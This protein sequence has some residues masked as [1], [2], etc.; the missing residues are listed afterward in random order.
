M[1]ISKLYDG[2]LK[3]CPRCKGHKY[4]RGQKVSYAE[5]SQL[6]NYKKIEAGVCFLCNGTGEAFYTEDN[7]VL[8]CVKSFGK[9]YIVEYSPVDGR[10]M[11]MI[12][13]FKSNESNNM[14]DK[15]KESIKDL[16]GQVKEED[17]FPSMYEMVWNDW[18]SVA[19]VIFKEYPNAKPVSIDKFYGDYE[20]E[21]ISGDYI[22]F[23]IYY[24]EY[25]LPIKPFYTNP[26][27]DIDVNDNSYKGIV[28]VDKNY[29]FAVSGT[30]IES[31]KRLCLGVKT[32][33]EFKYY[34]VE[35]IENI[36]SDNFDLDARMSML[37]LFLERDMKKMSEI[38][39]KDLY[40]SLSGDEL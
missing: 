13:S 26:P 10:K 35:N 7:R 17:F 8:K 19:D 5:G 32:T 16:T 38:I 6:P 30:Y 18:S 9:N 37:S 11:R 4:I 33:G 15:K 21:S 23:L 29:M 40:V 34:E 39:V 20:D 36:D 22:N 3:K 12:S 14:I 24:N 2:E 31:K 28:M 27:Y 1:D 25:G